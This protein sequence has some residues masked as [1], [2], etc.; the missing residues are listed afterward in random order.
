MTRPDTVLAWYRKR[1]AR[2]FDASKAGAS[3]R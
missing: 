1:V 2:K 3:T